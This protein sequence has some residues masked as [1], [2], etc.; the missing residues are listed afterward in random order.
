MFFLHYMKNFVLKK[1]KSITYLKRSLIYVWFFFSGI[2]GSQ[3]IRPPHSGRDGSGRQRIHAVQAA[4][5]ELAREGRNRRSRFSAHQRENRLA[6][7]F[8][9]LT[10]PLCESKQT[11][12]VLKVC[13]NDSANKM[14]AIVQYVL[15]KHTAKMFFYAKNFRNS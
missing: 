8:K 1:F 9:K 5:Q 3:T 2:H 13:A 6:G 15:C 4:V 14:N 12:I 7:V 11:A 10:F